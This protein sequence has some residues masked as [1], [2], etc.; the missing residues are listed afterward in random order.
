V[1][2]D[3][4]AAD[5]VFSADQLSPLIQSWLKKKG[6]N[7]FDEFA[8]FFTFLPPNLVGSMDALW[9]GRAL[10]PVVMG[11]AA[12]DVPSSS[13][14]ASSIRAL[15]LVEQKCSNEE[16]VGDL[17]AAGVEGTDRAAGGEEG[18]GDEGTPEPE[19]HHAVFVASCETPHPPPLPPC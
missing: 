14:L 15:R 18:F 17:G 5:R 12:V 9:E 6:G 16:A 11:A 1:L 4:S 7:G 19:H 2:S 13:T 10:S 8:N 3:I